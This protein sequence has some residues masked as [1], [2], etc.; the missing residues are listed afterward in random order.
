[1]AALRRVS[2]E[3][4]GPGA[5]GLLLPPGA[6]TVLIVRPRTLAW[7]LLLMRSAAGSAFRELT[8]T[9]APAVVQAFLADWIDGGSSFSTLLTS[10]DGFISRDNAAVYGLTSTSPTLVKTPLPAGQRSGILTQAGFQSQ[11]RRKLY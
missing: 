9:E 3:M 10:T 8:R 1:M 6:R 2:D 5:V 11:C 4:A 7:D